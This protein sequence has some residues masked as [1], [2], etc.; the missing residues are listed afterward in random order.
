MM[1]AATAEPTTRNLMGHRLSTVL[2]LLGC[3]DSP[4]VHWIRTPGMYRAI[5]TYAIIGSLRVDLR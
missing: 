2:N 5:S 1:P 4:Y 3:Q